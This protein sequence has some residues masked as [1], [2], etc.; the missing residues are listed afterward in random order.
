MDFSCLAFENLCSTV[1]GVPSVTIN[2]NP[3]TPQNTP[4]NTATVPG[5]TISQIVIGPSLTSTPGTQTASTAGSVSTTN[6]GGFPLKSSASPNTIILHWTVA[7]LG[8]VAG[9]LLVL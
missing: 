9:N 7:L 5:T 1:G 8:L 2:T 3:G 6:I 4:T